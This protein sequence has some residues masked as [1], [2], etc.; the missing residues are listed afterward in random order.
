MYVQVKS[1]CA[2]VQLIFILSIS[3]NEVVSTPGREI[4]MRKVRDTLFCS[5]ATCVVREEILR[6]PQVLS[7]VGRRLLFTS[8]RNYTVRTVFPVRRETKASGASLKAARKS[9][10]DEER[11]VND[12]RCFRGCS[13]GSSSEFLHDT[14][15][16]QR[17]LSACKRMSLPLVLLDVKRDTDIALT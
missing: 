15:L 9:I 16:F 10:C 14:P 8:P 6:Q 5:R 7:L 3:R 2:N 12:S 13:K 1:L 17:S 11:S 4:T